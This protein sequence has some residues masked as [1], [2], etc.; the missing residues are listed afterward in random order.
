MG[1]GNRPGSGVRLRWP[2]RRRRRQRGGDRRPVT[3]PR[4]GLRARIIS[5]FALGALVL[6][7]LLAATTFGLTRENL[8]RQRESSAVRQAYSNA[9]RVRDA[10]RAPEPQVQAVLDSLPLGGAQPL[11]I[12]RT[13]AFFQTLSFGPEAVPAALSA[14]V[15]DGVPARMRVTIDGEPH[16]I[17]GVPIVEA[18]AQYYEATSLADLVDTLASLTVSLV[19]AALVTTMAGALLGVWASRRVLRPLQ[20]VARAAA[21]IAAGDLQ[22]RLDVLADPDLSRLASSF[23]AM[24]EALQHRIQR[25][26]RF[27]SDVSHELRS[28]L[29]TLAAAV[30]VLEG[31]RSELPERLGHAVD[32]L[33]AEVDRFRRLVEDLLEI[34]RVDAGAVLFEPEPVLISDLVRHAAA[35][36]APGVEVDVD[37]RATDMVVEGDKRRLERVLANLLS[38]AERHGGGATR[39]EVTARG[40]HHVDIAVSDA[41]PGV[42]PADRDRIFERFSRGAGTAGRRGSG[43]DGVGLGLA[44]VAEHVRL[45]GGRVWVTDNP[46][47]RGARFVVRL[48]ATPVSDLEATGDG[49]PGHG[50]GDRTDHGAPAEA[51]P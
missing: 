39:V 8:L 34:S 43:G 31:R 5:A 33:V 17:V 49:P 42:P 45:H 25:D 9:S 47:G 4:L 15:A 28:P 1:R 18:D 50:P 38:N 2:L 37:D 44:L 41:G 14:L 51:A 20:E 26:A 22:T 19:G 16:L 27:A 40:R 10:L 36:M 29:M 11:V 35:A 48:P 6:S 23:N 24:A 7:T 3:V 32:L 13:E 46:R 12:T 30:E 21:A